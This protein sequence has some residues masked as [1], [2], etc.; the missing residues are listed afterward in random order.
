MQNASYRLIYSLP[1][2]HYYQIEQTM[3]NCDGNDD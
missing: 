2:V 1:I 3:A